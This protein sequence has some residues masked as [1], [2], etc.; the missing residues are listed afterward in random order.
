MG[1]SCQPK[2][3][4]VRVDFAFLFSVFVSVFA[5]FF[6]DFLAAAVAMI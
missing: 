3:R 5:G 2:N 6:T 1:V 4:P